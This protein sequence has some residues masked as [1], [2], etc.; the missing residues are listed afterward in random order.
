M[1]Q[2]TL[3]LLARD[4]GGKLVVDTDAGLPADHPLRV[5]ARW[6]GRGDR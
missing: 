2:R 4:Y 6:G 5:L 1:L 3:S